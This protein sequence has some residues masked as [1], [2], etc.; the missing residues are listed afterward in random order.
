MASNCDAFYYVEKG[1]TCPSITSAYGISTADFIKWN[2]SV[3]ADCTGLWAS[4]YM[5]VGVIGQSP[6]TTT[7][8]TTTSAPDPT[9]PPNGI[10]TPLPIQPGMVDNCDAFHLVGAGDICDT[11]AARYKISTTQ[12]VTWNPSV[13]SSCG[14]MWANTYVCVS[15][16]GHTPT[17]TTTTTASVPTTTASGPSP[18]QS[19]IDKTCV[20]FYKAQA[21]DTCTTIAQQKYRYIYSLPLFQRWNPAVGSDCSGLF[22]G[23]YYCVATEQHQPMPGIINTCRG[24]HQVKDG[25]S[26]WAIQQKYGITAAQFNNWNPLVGSSCA[27]LWVKYFVCV[28]V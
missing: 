25:D 16:I 8:K 24:Y 26:C 6:G 17:T 23:Y 22:A 7:T 20:S 21:G 14:G 3:S 10:E 27:S 1:D 12:F 11:I 9:T 5:C 15:I 19:G 28:G 13:G 18:T 4:Y 2:P